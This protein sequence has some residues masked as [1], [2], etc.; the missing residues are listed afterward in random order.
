MPTKQQFLTVAEAAERLAIGRRRM[1]RMIARR[2][3]RAVALPVQTGRGLRT[4]YRIPEDEIA[5][6]IE[7]ETRK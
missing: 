6:L 4:S 5:K 2:E 7:K 1:A 3:I